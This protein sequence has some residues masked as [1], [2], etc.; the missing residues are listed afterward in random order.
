MGRNSNLYQ[1]FNSILSSVNTE[2]NSHICMIH[3]VN[4]FADFPHI[5]KFVNINQNVFM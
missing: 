1:E 4:K 3:F 2:K 5:D